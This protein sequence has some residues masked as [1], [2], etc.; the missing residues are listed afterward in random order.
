MAPTPFVPRLKPKTVAL[1]IK[2]THKKSSKTSTTSGG[3]KKNGDP[4]DGE[5]L[6]TVVVRAEREDP[7]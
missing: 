5:F 6:R 7:V 3:K 2:D 4:K 1:G